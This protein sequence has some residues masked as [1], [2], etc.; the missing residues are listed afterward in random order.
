MKSLIVKTG[1]VL[2]AG[3]LLLSG[4][5][6]SGQTDRPGEFYAA[7]Y[8][9][10]GMV[11]HEPQ[12]PSGLHSYAGDTTWNH[13]GWN[14]IRV[15]GI[16]WHPAQPGIIFLACGNGVLRSRD[17]GDS[18]KLTTDWRITEALDVVPDP[19]NPQRVY[20]ATG[21]GIWKS[22]DQGETWLERNQGIRER[23]CNAIV[24]D[25]KVKNRVIAG[26]WDGLYLST[27]AA[28]SWEPVGPRDVRITDLV[29]S[30]ADPTRWLAATQENGLLLSNDNGIHWKVLPS[31]G[32]SLSLMSVAVDPLNADHL[33]AAGWGTGVY[34]SRNGGTSWTRRTRGLPTKDFYQVVFDPTQ[35]GRLWAAT[36]EKGVWYSDDMGKNWQNAGLYGTLVYDM[37]F[38]QWEQTE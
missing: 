29:Q 38:I 36:V 17:Y 7:L 24:A 14:N 19:H 30:E 32:N 4:G 16:G 23:Y 31:P 3:F 15:R 5:S 21:F 13:I 27:D 11:T 6:V 8:W 2:I 34:S 10:I 18:W 9:S 26:A 12:P 25:R 20:I 1:A 33:A 22:P 28:N 37:V 35:E